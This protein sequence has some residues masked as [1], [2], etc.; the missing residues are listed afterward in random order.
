[1]NTAVQIH[2]TGE[3]HLC[4]HL[5]RPLAHAG[6]QVGD[7]KRIRGK[8]QPSAT[9]YFETRQLFYFDNGKQRPCLDDQ[10]WSADQYTFSILQFLFQFTRFLLEILLGSELHPSLNGTIYPWF[11]MLWSWEIS[12]E[13]QAFPFFFSKILF[14]FLLNYLSF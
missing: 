1:M 7:T 14:F 10:W 8:D 3:G 9:L 5:P 2:I 6:W 13:H 12:K 4:P 11:S